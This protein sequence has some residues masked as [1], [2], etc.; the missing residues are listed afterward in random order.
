MER[1][2]RLRS[3]HATPTE[4]MDMPVRLYV[5]DRAKRFLRNQMFLCELIFV[6]FG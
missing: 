2:N 4:N 3:V 1:A 6:T 5:R